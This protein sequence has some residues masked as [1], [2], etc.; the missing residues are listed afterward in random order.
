MKYI[1]RN[2]ANP[3]P[4]QPAG[5]S[6]VL[7]WWCSWMLSCTLHI[8]S[9]LSS[10]SPAREFAR[11]ALLESAYATLAANTVAV[12]AIVTTLHLVATITALQDGLPLPESPLKDRP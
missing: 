12:V 3:G 2:S 7:L 11:S 4:D 10:A 1:L 5:S 9:I 8:I 6:N